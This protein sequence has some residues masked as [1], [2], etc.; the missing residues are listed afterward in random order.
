MNIR[1]GCSCLDL[2]VQ[3]L[4]VLILTFAS[5]P[6]PRVVVGSRGQS[7]SG[8]VGTRNSAGG[9]CTL[10]FGVPDSGSGT[11]ASSWPLPN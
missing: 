10:V 9:S 7:L 4:G 3:V 6:L 11:S 8:Q 5:D 2:E 1:S